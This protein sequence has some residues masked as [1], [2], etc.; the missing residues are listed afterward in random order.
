MCPPICGGLGSRRC[1][2]GPRDLLPLT[3]SPQ[4]TGLDSLVGIESHKFKFFAWVL[5]FVLHFLGLV[6]KDMFSQ[7][8]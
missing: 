6:G 7:V 2:R 1:T 4:G 3:K 5:F 8:L